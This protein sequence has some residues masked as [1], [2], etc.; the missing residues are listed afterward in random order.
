MVVNGTEPSL[1][2][3]DELDHLKVYNKEQLE[4]LWESVKPQIATIGNNTFKNYKPYI[5]ALGII[6]GVELFQVTGNDDFFY[7]T[8]RAGANE[9]AKA[10][11]KAAEEYGANK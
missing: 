8:D 7:I 11:R 5:V 1:V 10:L 2:I 9:A 6:N 3:L 4:E